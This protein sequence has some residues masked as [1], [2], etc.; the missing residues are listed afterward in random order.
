[1]FTAHVSR[2][3]WKYLDVYY[4]FIRQMYTHRFEVYNRKG[5]I[6]SCAC[7]QFLPAQQLAVTCK[8]R[9]AIMSRAFRIYPQTHASRC[10]GTRAL[11]SRHPY[12]TTESWEGASMNYYFWSPIV[13]LLLYNRFKNDTVEWYKWNACIAYRSNKNL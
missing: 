12:M 6:F 10:T 2:C 13:S 5:S 9:L 4:G 11:L 3:M 8:A 1:M 7:S